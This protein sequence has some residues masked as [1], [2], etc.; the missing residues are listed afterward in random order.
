[1]GDEVR[2]RR[3]RAVWLTL[4]AALTATGCYG[5]HGTP[6]SPDASTPCEIAP[7]TAAG[8]FGGRPWSFAFGQLWPNGASSIATLYAP[9]SSTPGR[10]WPVMEGD[11]VEFELEINEG[12]EV[13]VGDR[14]RVRFLSGDEPTRG[15]EAATGRAIV[16][17]ALADTVR[18]AVC[19]RDDRGD[20]VVSGQF[21]IARC[22]P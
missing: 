16:R 22:S 4:S 8:T 10:C 9:D 12:E 7:T 18:G 14:L 21:E 11:R 1:M 6:D 3:S 17:E 13:R 2:E 20:V 15:W 19:A 5:A